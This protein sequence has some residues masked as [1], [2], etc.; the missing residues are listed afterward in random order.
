MLWNIRWSCIHVK[1]QHMKRSLTLSIPNPCREK[2]NTFTHSEKGGHC[3]R[4]DKHV[5][6]F[7]KLNDE[8]IIRFFQSSA[9][10]A[11]GRFLP[12]QLKRY[13]G[14]LSGQNKTGFKFMKAG[15]LLALLSLVEGA[16]AQENKAG[17]KIENI[18]PEDAP[19]VVEPGQEQTLISGVVK[20]DE[21]EI[22]PFAGANVWLKGT[23]FGASTDITGAFSFTAPL[24]PGDVLV[25]SFIGFRTKE[26]RI[27]TVRPVHMEV[28]MDVDDMEMMGEVAITGVYHEPKS[29]WWKKIKSFF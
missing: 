12:G 29:S 3:N 13:T 1:I 26:I 15:V 18:E 10:H 7:T 17:Y 16:E 21:G 8:Q 25:V 9:P 11:C 2:W 19:S 4:C 28:T 27:G 6:D 24:R 14:H 20:L 5:I 23:Q 22:V